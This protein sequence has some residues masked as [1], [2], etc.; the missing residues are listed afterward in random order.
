MNFKIT[1]K[2]DKNKWSDFV[3]HHQSGNIFQSPE[4]YDVYTKSKYFEPIVIGV[5]D[6]EEAVV[7]ILLAVIQ[8]EHNGIL[9]I[10]SSRSIIIGGPLIKDNNPEVLDL[11]LKGYNDKIK[12][13]A[14]YSQIRNISD[15]AFLKE[16]FCNNGF[17][18]NPHLDIMINL[19]V[20]Q[21]E[22]VQNIKHEKRRNLTKS[23]NKGIEFKE[24]DKKEDIQAGLQLIRS[25]YKRIKLPMPDY[26]L[27]NNAFDTLYKVGYIKIFGAYS[28]LKIIGIRIVLTYKE[29]IYD[30]FAG[31]DDT[32]RNLYPNDF[33]IINILL[34]GLDKEYSVFDFG[35]AGKPDIPYGV[36]DHKMK[37][38]GELVEFGRFEK[39]HNKLLYKIG[40]LGLELYKRKI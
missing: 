38:G 20:S 24:I 37:F 7:S 5:T 2:P 39:I 10:F 12:G 31:D 30:W 6:R 26:S 1:T 33:L 40:K 9:G 22:L 19:N 16:I 17:T 27:F 29:L 36:R 4:M 8:K 13:N 21:I 32:S 14:I 15:Q 23:R 28:D 3:L 11:L 25:T 35:G 34:W 18:Y